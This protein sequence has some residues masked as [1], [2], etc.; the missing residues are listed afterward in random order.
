MSGPG[1]STIFTGVWLEKHGVADN[2]FVRHRLA[3]WPHFCRH[4]KDAHPFAWTA[5][6]CDWP[7]ISRFI[8]NEGRGEWHEIVDFD[9]VAT[10]ELLAKGGDYARRDVEVTA[11]ALEHLRISDPDF[12]FVYYGNVDEVGHGAGNMQGEFSPDNA[13][14]MAAITRVDQHVAE[15]LA[16]VQARPKLAEESW[17]VLV[18]TDH[19]GRLES[20]GG[21]S[22]EERT[23]WM[24]ASGGGAPP[25]KVVPGP[26]PQTV[27]AP[28]VFA[29]LG[30]PILPEWGW[31]AEPFAISLS[32][33]AR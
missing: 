30:V 19:G 26:I 15:V 6:L 1:W 32:P 18:T 28:T 25:G 14:Y 24:I 17:L 22:P 12:M 16:A 31:E 11:R 5:S 8:V 27:I 10:P 21:Q 9:F 2:R 4:L 3:Q 23:I 13:A 20:H 33:I 29:Y 7:P